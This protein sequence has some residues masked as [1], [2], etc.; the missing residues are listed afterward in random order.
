M[1]LSEIAQRLLA[2]ICGPASN[3]SNKETIMHKKV[4]NLILGS[5]SLVA[6]V[7]ASASATIFSETSRLEA[8]QWEFVVS[9][10]MIG[11]PGDCCP[12]GLAL[13]CDVPAYCDAGYE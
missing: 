7:I 11:C 10:V 2:S 1:E 6:L 8:V 3:R 13:C 9:T 12:G 5:V 4:R